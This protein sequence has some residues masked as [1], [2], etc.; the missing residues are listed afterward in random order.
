MN[1]KIITDKQVC[2]LWNINM[3]LALEYQ[4][5]GVVITESEAKHLMAPV[6][7]LI[8]H[9][10]KMPSS[11]P[12]CIIYDKDIYGV[13][14]LYSLQLES[15]SKNIM[16]MANGNEIVRAIFKIQMEQL[17]QEVWTPLCFAEKVSQ[18]KFSTKRFVGDALII[19]DSKNFHLCDH[20]NYNDLFRNHRIKGGY[21]LI[22]D[23]LDEEFKFYKIESKN[24]VLCSL[25]N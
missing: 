3:I 21:I 22:E 7:T 17:Q 18:V 9:K 20:E 15:L 19:L 24:V 5:Q 8:K 13:K 14:D 6:N 2:K 1:R 4:L 10:C 16:Y 12:N 25:N 11:L 23:V